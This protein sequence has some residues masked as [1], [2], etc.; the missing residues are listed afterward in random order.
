MSGFRIA[1]F[2]PNNSVWISHWA[3]ELIK[4]GHI[5][6]F[7]SIFPPTIHLEVDFQVLPI[8]WQNNYFKFW[9]NRKVVEK[10]LT[11]FRADVAHAFY[12]TNYG[13][14]ATNQKV[15]PSIVTLVGS[16]L[17]VEP[18]RHVFFR[19]ANQFVICHAR[20]LNPVSPQLAQVLRTDYRVEAE[21]EMFPEGIDCQL[22]F[23][24]HQK[25]PSPIRLISTRNFEPIY[26]YAELVTI[27]PELLSD[28]E[29]L[30][31]HFFGA[32]SLW[33]EYRN[34][35]N[36]FSQI[37]WHGWQP[38]EKLAEEL[39]LS[40]IY[41]STSLSDGASSSLLEAMACGVFPVVSDIPANRDWIEEGENGFLVPKGDVGQLKQKISQAITDPELRQKAAKINQELVLQ[42]A[43]AG[44]V[45]SRLEDIYQRLAVKR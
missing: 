29:D 4:R 28:F 27:I 34:Q 18:Q 11:D 42:K 23:P 26:N 40:D 14:L 13:V 39:R 43:S 12:S 20:V 8:R 25:S 33:Q 41:L 37:V 32:G 7:L 9:L 10:I 19:L 30:E 31:I 1:F 3:S 6:L 24:S 44:I 35:L 15:C 17:L 45:I 38:R 36:E 2:A 22:F 5:V 21:I 16:D